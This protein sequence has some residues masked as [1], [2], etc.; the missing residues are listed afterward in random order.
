VVIPTRNRAD[1]L[2]ECIE[3]L[4]HE[5]VAAKVAVEAIVIDTSSSPTPFS[6]VENEYLNVHYRYD[7][8]RPFSLIYAR[9]QGLDLARANIVAYI[10]DDCFVLSGWLG[11]L[12]EPYQSADTVATGGRIVYHPWH[13]VRSGEP[14]AVLDVDSDKV[15]AE[16]DRVVPAPITV[17]HLPGG[18]FS[19]LKSRAVAVGG[20]DP[21]F[22]GSANLEETDF[23]I[24][25]GKLGGNIVFHP[26]AVVEHRAAPRTDG[27]ARSGT[28]YLY[29]KSAVRNRIYLLRKH[30]SGAAVRRGVVRQ[31][32]DLG[33]GLL[34]SAVQ[35]GIFAAASLV[36]IIEGLTTPVTGGKRKGE[37]L[38]M[39][40]E[41]ITKFL[42][43][44]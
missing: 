13:P 25:L 24:R 1:V 31:C 11:A 36:G 3:R 35:S 38:S 26:R 39:E 6:Y 32:K 9:N 43:K 44:Q 17:S 14:I 42:S 12:L 4:G 30:G 8:D 33:A 2:E 40:M 18:N 10:D 20:F 37:A 5:A 28:N 16:W 22:T 21:Q 15:W 19:V 29:R 23:F 7:G 27:I 34:K 41:G